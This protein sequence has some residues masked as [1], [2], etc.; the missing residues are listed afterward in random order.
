MIEEREAGFVS[1]VRTDLEEARR[2]AKETG[3]VSKERLQRLDRMSS[4][5]EQVDR[6]VRLF[7]KTARLD[8]GALIDV[9]RDTAVRK[10]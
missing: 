1:R 7:L 5:A 2:L 3:D 6:A 10:H 4:L 9:L 8:V